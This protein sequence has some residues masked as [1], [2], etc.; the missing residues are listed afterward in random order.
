VCTIRNTLGK[1]VNK[2]F[3]CFLCVY[4]LLV[5]MRHFLH[6]DAAY[7]TVGLIRPIVHLLVPVFEAL[8]GYKPTI[9]FIVELIASFLSVWFGNYIVKKFFEKNNA[10]E[11]GAVMQALFVLFILA[12]AV[13]VASTYARNLMVGDPHTSGPKLLQIGAAKASVDGSSSYLSPHVVSGSSGEVVVCHDGACVEDVP[14]EEYQRTKSGESPPSPSPSSK[15]KPKASA[16]QPKPTT[17]SVVARDFV[18]GQDV[19]VYTL[20]KDL[21]KY[22]F[23]LFCALG[24]TL[25]AASTLLLGYLF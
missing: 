14:E 13:Y 12:P 21:G 16:E 1:M 23:L 6:G 22:Q 24:V 2:Y 15:P 25:S 3:K 4:V 5:A 7:F 19:A 9:I 10:A 18:D 20:M 17:T 11:R 8:L